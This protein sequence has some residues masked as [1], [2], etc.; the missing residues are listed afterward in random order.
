MKYILIRYGEIWLK[1]QKRNYFEQKLIN[2]IINSFNLA[3]HSYGEIIRK[4][5]RILIESESLC[6]SLKKV[7]GIVS[8]SL[9]EKILPDLDSIKKNIEKNYLNSIKEP[10]CV[11]VQRIDKI[12]KI[13]SRGLEK[14]IG[15]FIVEKTNK[16]VNLKNPATLLGLEIYSESAY[17]FTEEL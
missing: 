5:G 1:G 9:A 12:G 6:D 4:G 7:S 16:K 8:Y 11:R 2:N 3:K 10:F 14:E 15:S 17:L 13:N